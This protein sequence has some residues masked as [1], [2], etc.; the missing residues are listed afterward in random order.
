MLEILDATIATAGIILALSL[1]V[2]AVQQIIKQVFDLKS[3]YMRNELLALFNNAGTSN[4]FMANF[5]PLGRLANDADEMARKI[6]G[7]LE[8]KIASFGYKDLELLEDVNAARLKD[9]VMS[10]PVAAEVALKK[11]FD[12][13]ASEID[14]WFDLSKK[15]FQDHYERRMKLW[16]FMVSTVVVIGLNSNLF[17]VYQ[18]FA[19]NKTLRDATVAWAEEAVRTHVV[20]VKPTVDSTEV[21][22]AATVAIK[23]KIAEIQSYMGDHSLQLCRWN[24]VRG[25]SIHIFT[26]PFAIVTKAPAD[27]YA[28]AAKNTLG[29]LAMTLLV[30]LGAPFWY[31]FLKMV[32]GVKE[33]LNNASR[34]TV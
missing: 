11:E 33:K 25:D 4:S 5:K 28:A 31:D 19:A 23:E 27:F 1:I 8:Q 34:K 32:M 6:V 3:S 30:S 26:S 21:D 13:A 16:S 12:V 14:R 2:Q 18:D 10:L 9:L 20:N 7:Q 17:V 15:A 29:W 24:T 22:S